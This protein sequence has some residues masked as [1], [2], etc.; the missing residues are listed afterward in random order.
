MN[1]DERT[2][3]TETKD[4]LRPQ[5]YEPLHACGAEKMWYMLNTWEED[6]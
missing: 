1:E 6:T 4:D 2:E 5:Y 3:Q